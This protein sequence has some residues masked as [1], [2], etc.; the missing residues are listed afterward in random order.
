[1][2]AYCRNN[3]VNFLDS[4]GNVPEPVPSLSDFYYMHKAVQMDIAEEYGYAI[5]VYIRSPLGKGYLDIYDPEQNQ[6]YEVKSR[7]QAGLL[8]T[9]IQLAKYDSSHISDIRF[10]GYF[11]ADS[12][13]RG[14]QYIS[15]Q[16]RYK[17][18]D[19]YYKSDGNGLI[20]YV[21]E[22]NYTRYN[23]AL[24][25]AAVFGLAVMAGCMSSVR[26]QTISKDM[27]FSCM[28]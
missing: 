12:P 17:Y 8:A 10:V 24:A 14:T 28:G 3:P 9:D 11:F 15:G 13:Q 2:F 23:Q 1:M 21:Y 22:V 27:S 6:Y 20:T 16:C 4:C 26:H 7:P 25:T 18:W 5:E 19:I